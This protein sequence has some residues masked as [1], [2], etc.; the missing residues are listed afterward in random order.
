M[1]KPE[2]LRAATCRLN[3][4]TAGRQ[5]WKTK[6]WATLQPARQSFGTLA[7]ANAMEVIE[8]PQQTQPATAPDVTEQYSSSPLE[9]QLVTGD[10]FNPAPKRPLSPLSPHVTTSNRYALLQE[11]DLDLSLED[12]ALPRVVVEDPEFPRATTL[13]KKSRPNKSKHAHFERATKLIREKDVESNI[14]ADQMGLIN[15][16]AMSSVRGRFEKAAS[17]TRDTPTMGA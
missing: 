16:V 10:R 13:A 17:R 7:Q 5:Q 14:L 3:K 11:D 4:D 9:F 12:F 1:R 8:T 15:D 2:A 6:T